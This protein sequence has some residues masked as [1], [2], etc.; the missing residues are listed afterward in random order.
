VFS[1]PKEETMG[2]LQILTTQSL[3][4]WVVVAGFAMIIRG[5]R[6]ASAVMRWPVVATL[7]LLR[8]AI[9]GVFVA[10]GNFIRGR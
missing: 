4:F 3:V 9:G 10:L 2:E 1:P 7:R 8:R 6:A 5:P